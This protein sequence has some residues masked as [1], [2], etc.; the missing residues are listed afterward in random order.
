MG[1]AVDTETG[2]IFADRDGL[3]VFRDRNG[4]VSD[5]RYTS[6]QATFG[7]VEPEICYTEISFAT[8]S[9]KIKN[10]VSIANEGGTASD[11]DGPG[12]DRALRPRTYRRF[13]LIHVDGAESTTIAQ[14]HLDFFAY[15]ANRIETLTVDLRD[16]HA[17]GARARPRPRSPLADSSTPTRRGRTDRRGSTDSRDRGERD[18]ER[19]DDFVRDV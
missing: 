16:A 13:D 6:V 8:D 14:R 4:L 15:A 12:L 9:D 3:L 1:L 10:V 2:T 5:P 11:A 18:A 7:E 17:R 19:M